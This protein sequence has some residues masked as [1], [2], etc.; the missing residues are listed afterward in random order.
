MELLYMWVD[1]YNNIY[2]KGFNFSHKYHFTYIEE[3]LEIKTISR[4]SINIFN[5]NFINVIAIAGENGSGKTSLMSFVEFFFLNKRDQ[6]FRK[7]I[8]AYED[9]NGIIKIFGHSINKL[10]NQE[11]LLTEITNDN[12]ELKKNVVPILISSG[13]EIKNINHR[14]SSFMKIEGERLLN[15]KQIEHNKII[16]EELEKIFEVFNWPNVSKDEQESFEH[17]KIRLL[18]WS[19]VNPSF[20]NDELNRII[21]FICKHNP[22]EYDFI[23]DLGLTFNLNFLKNFGKTIDKENKLLNQLIGSITNSKHQP[24]ILKKENRIELKDSILSL[25]FLFIYYCGKKRVRFQKFNI[26][27]IF[28]NL[29][30]LNSVKERSN[31]IDN[32]IN[33]ENFEYSGIHTKFNKIKELNSSLNQFLEKLEFQYHNGTYYLEKNENSLNFINGFFEFW[34]LDEFAFHFNVN[35]MSAGEKSI[36]TL[37]SRLFY[38]QKY[39]YIK[40]TQTIWLFI[41]E[42]ELYL[43]PEWQRKFFFNLHTYLPKFFSQNNVQL[44]ITTHSPFVLSDLPKENIILLQKNSLNSECLATNMDII[45]QTFGANIHELLSN[46]FFMHDGVT[47]KFAE[48]IINDL[49]RFLTGDSANRIWNETLALLTI[50][51]IGEPIIKGQLHMLFDIKFNSKSEIEYLE[52]QI[53]QLQQKLENKKRNDSDTKH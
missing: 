45:P 20:N 48:E 14:T 53:N 24:Q 23:P 28:K 26:D 42:G 5:E 52:S 40:E 22:D 46:S 39:T 25:I 12:T 27:E 7:A 47:G 35:D 32:F 43:H 30:K 49:F 44:F 21:H 15:Q 2:R 13:I 41:D 37:L 38:V 9:N 19:G 51:K 6:L 50:N 29:E 33:T 31:Y 10:K 1:S 8:L 16:A 34:Q 17:N 11:N 4:D 3:T 36:L 18:N